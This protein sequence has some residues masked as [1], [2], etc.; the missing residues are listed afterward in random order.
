MGIAVTPYPLLPAAAVELIGR[1]LS[2]NWHVLDIGAGGSTI[3]YAKRARKVRAIETKLEWVTVLEP[4]IEHQ[5]GATVELMLAEPTAESI[6]SLALADEPYDFV[7]IDTYPYI[8]VPNFTCELK[9][10]D[11][12]MGLL[13]HDLLKPTAMWVLDDWPDKL[14]W[15]DLDPLVFKDREVIDVPQHGRP[16]TRIVL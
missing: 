3:Y 15:A 10:S 5:R 11:I 4:Y 7:S 1:K 16:G 6:C 8:S 9:R 12:L 2:P 14:M 13:E